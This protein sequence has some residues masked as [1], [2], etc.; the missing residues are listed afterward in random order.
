M[1]KADTEFDL[2]ACL[3]ENQDLKYRDFQAGLIPNIDKDT[4]IGVRVPVLRKIAKDL[5]KS[6]KG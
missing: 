5:Y 1:K 4:M 6:L 3:F 2:R